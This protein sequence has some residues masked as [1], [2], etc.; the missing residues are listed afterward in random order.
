MYI[1]Q[2]NMEVKDRRKREQAYALGIYAETN[3]RL[4][5]LEQ[6]HGVKL[7]SEFVTDLWLKISRV[8]FVFRDRW[9]L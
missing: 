4:A 1:I 7:H 5:T 9:L 3:Q 8:F 2:I 6:E